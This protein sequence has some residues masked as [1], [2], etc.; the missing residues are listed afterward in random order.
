MQIRGERSCSLNSSLVFGTCLRMSLGDLFK[1][2]VEEENSVSYYIFEYCQ[3]QAAKLT[4][5]KVCYLS[6]TTRKKGKND[7]DY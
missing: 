1:R 5:Q 6:A 3:Q 2:S 4:V 7:R